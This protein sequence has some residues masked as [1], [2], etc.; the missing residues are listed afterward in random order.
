MEEL[1]EKIKYVRNAKET[2]DEKMVQYV[3]YE[4]CLNKIVDATDYDNIR[5]Y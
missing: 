5:R 3:Q 2:M 1:T 4:K